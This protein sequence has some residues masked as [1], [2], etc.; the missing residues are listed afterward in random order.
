MIKFTSFTFL[1]FI[2][3]ASTAQISNTIF[4]NN[5]SQQKSIS[6]SNQRTAAANKQRLDSIVSQLYKQAY[7]YDAADNLI[8]QISYRRST[9]LDPFV[10]T[11]KVEYQYDAAG[12]IILQIEYHWDGVGNRFIPAY[13]HEN[14]YD[15]NR[16]LT[17]DIF[18]NWDSISATWIQVQKIENIFGSNGLVSNTHNYYWTI[19]DILVEENYIE[20]LYN[21]KLLVEETQYN[22]GNVVQNQKTYAY[23]TND[24][25]ISTTTTSNEGDLE[26]KSEYT[27]DSENNVT[28]SLMSKWNTGIEDWE[29]KYKTEYEFDLQNNKTIS[30]Q[31]DWDPQ[32]NMWVYTYKSAYSY[33]N[34]YGIIDLIIP[35][36][37]DGLF[38]HKLTEIDYYYY[39]HEEWN[40]QEERIY[41][42][43][44]VTTT[45][46]IHSETNVLTVYPNPANDR[47]VFT[48]KTSDAATLELFNQQGS[49]VYNN[50]IVMNQPVYVESLVQ[51]IYF[52]RILSSNAESYNGTLII[53]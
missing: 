6:I 34:T 13:K 50:T 14:V 4:S 3:L 5:L 24:N 10:T 53:E 21:N 32:K 25:L 38:I 48:N 9:V 15:V 49:L 16:N 39:D 22:L 11:A 12:N 36:Q 2:A 45:G 28:L 43:K 46:I 30:I 35:H 42:Y 26:N 7:M 17:S 40:E 37:L 1:F 8:F 29:M 47:V 52:Y 51:G 23:D 27:Y 20:F 41:Y 18:Y 19:S 44:D 33:D 31:S